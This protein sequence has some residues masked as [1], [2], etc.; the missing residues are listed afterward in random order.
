MSVANVVATY[1][2]LVP[3]MPLT[4]PLYV[5]NGNKVI[6]EVDIKSNKPWRDFLDACRRASNNHVLVNATV[7]FG[8]IPANAAHTEAIP[9]GPVTPL[10]VS[11]GPAFDSFVAV[12]QPQGGTGLIFVASMYVFGKI[13]VYAVNFTAAPITPGALNMEFIITP[14]TL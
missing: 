10:P 7:D 4:T 14:R 2:Q 6:G 5:R 1:Q 12:A 3:E 13:L 11:P 8:T 9:G